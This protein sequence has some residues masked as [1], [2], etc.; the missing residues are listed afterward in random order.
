MTFDPFARYGVFIAVSQWMSTRAA[1]KTTSRV[2]DELT[3]TLENRRAE[4][5]R[6]VHHRMR[7]VRS[8]GGGDRNGLDEAESADVGVQEDIG[9]ALIELK[10]ETLDKID[11]AL[12]RIAGGNYG[13][14]VNCGGQIAETRLRALPFALRCKDCEQAREAESPVT[15]SWGSRL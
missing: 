12:R 1:K 2:L 6:D 10:A 9:F 15:G 11:N 13:D 14:C 7:E 8:D 5:M 4:L 3:T